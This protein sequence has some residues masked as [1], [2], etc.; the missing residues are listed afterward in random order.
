MYQGDDLSKYI[1]IRQ[2][3]TLLT[4]I[5]F[6]SI[7]FTLGTLVKYYPEEITWDSGKQAFVFPLTQ[8]QTFAMRGG[9]DLQVRAKLSSDNKVRSANIISVEVKDS[10]TNKTF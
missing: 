9:A 7:Q 3:N 6:D 10:I 8:A 4:P 1:Q 2:G 5:A